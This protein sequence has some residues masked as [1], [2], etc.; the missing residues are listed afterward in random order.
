MS[1]APSPRSPQS[2]ADDMLPG[3]RLLLL[4]LALVGVD[5]RVVYAGGA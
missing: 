1:I 3:M 2:P 4:V 5:L